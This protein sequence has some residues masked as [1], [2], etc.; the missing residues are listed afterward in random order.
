MRHNNKF[1]VNKQMSIYEMCCKC[2]RSAS[3]YIKELASIPTKYFKYKMSKY[4]KNVL[5]LLFA[6]KHVLGII[7]AQQ[8]H[9]K[10]FV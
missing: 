8:K 2:T 1:S 9:N 4:L 5:E 6:M 3:T 10:Y 7:V